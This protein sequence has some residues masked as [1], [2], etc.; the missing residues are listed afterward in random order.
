MA[1]GECQLAALCIASALLGVLG[2]HSDFEALLLY[3]ML[4]A[5]ILLEAYT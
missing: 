1:A 4:Q 2:P 5:V 3:T